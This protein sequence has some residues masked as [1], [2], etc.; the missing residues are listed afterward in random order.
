MRARF[1]LGT[2]I[3]ALAACGGGSGDGSSG[4]SGSFHVL[5]VNVAAGQVWKINRPL[6]VRFSEDVDFSTVS[7]NTIRVIDSTGFSAIG[8]FYQPTDPD[9]GQL[10]PRRVAFQPTCPALEDFSDAG[11]VP[12]R[13]YTLSVSASGGVPTLTSTSGESLSGGILRSFVTPD[14]DNPLELFQDSVPGPPRVIVLP[15]RPESGEVVDPDTAATHVEI[16]GVRR[17]FGREASS[18]QG[19]LEPGLELPLSHYSLPENQVAFVLQFDQ[20][21][22]ASKTNLARVRLEYAAASGWERVSAVAELEGN[23]TQDGARVR[24]EPRGILPQNR[25]LRVVVEAGF[26]D[27]SGDPTTAIVDDVA[28]AHTLTGGSPNPLFPDVD[29]PE[30]DELLEGFAFEELEDQSAVFPVPAASWQDG[31]LEANFAFSGTGGV[32]G[33]FDWHIPPGT[34]LVLDTN[35]A[36]T[37]RGGH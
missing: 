6:E 17:F 2:A 25:D 29:N 30:V 22:L 1:S 27:L 35:S 28:L 20:S 21:V 36:D 32:N 12:G 13:T 34:E 4:A 37:T 33:E 15:E 18:Q 7:L 31:R 5:G 14:S 9:T 24:V 26:L 23:C 8:Y 3:L 16:G 11:L 10:D 19:L